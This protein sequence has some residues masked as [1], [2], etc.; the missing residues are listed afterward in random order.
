VA[1]FFDYQ[2]LTSARV[3]DLLSDALNALSARGEISLEYRTLTFNDRG[4]VE[5]PSIRAA[6]AAACADTQDA[7]PAYHRQVITSLSSGGFTEEQLRTEF[8]KQAGIRGSALVEMQNCYDQRLT[9]TFVTEV[10]AEASH[11]LSQ[12]NTRTTP[13]FFVNDQLLDWRNLSVEAGK[14]SEQVLRNAITNLSEG[15]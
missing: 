15:K 5:G 11:Y 4:R 9:A 1:V 14:V 12:H 2:D 3:S 6:V 8:A 7:F 13:A 10:A